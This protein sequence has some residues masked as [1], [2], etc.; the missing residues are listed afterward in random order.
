M[1]LAAF[2]GKTTQKGPPLLNETPGSPQVDMLSFGGDEP[3]VPEKIK[4]VGNPAVEVEKKFNV[5][6]SLVE[7]K[8]KT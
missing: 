2:M 6:Q 4:E 7:N 8:I 3:E 1:V 5:Y